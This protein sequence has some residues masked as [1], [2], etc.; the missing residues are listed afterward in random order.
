MG[1]VA[2]FVKVFKGYISSYFANLEGEIEESL[3]GFWKVTVD[4]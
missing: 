2:R 3:D 4:D 1:Y